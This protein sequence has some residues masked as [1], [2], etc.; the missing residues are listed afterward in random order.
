MVSKFKEKL[1]DEWFLWHTVSLPP[2]KWCER[3][4]VPRK[5]ERKCNPKQIRKLQKQTFFPKIKW[6]NKLH[7]TPNF[8][9]FQNYIFQNEKFSL[10]SGEMFLE[11]QDKGLKIDFAQKKL[12][13]EA[14]ALAQK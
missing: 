12:R 13:L 14:S 6:C 3:K 5:R 7:P 9:V 2:K 11:A 1:F 10:P 8:S 4:E